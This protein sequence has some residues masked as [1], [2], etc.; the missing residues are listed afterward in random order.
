MV[1]EGVV[2]LSLLNFQIACKIRRKMAMRRMPWPAVAAMYR[3]VEGGCLIVW[4]EVLI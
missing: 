4:D 2:S 1:G 3:A